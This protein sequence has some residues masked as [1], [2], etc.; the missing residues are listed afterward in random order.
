[1]QA[2]RLVVTIPRAMRLYA[3]R[4]WGLD[5]PTTRLRMVGTA[6]M[7]LLAIALVE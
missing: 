6:T 4:R 1:M 2:G 5:R 3:I 7:T